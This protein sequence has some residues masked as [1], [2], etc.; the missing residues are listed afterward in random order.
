MGMLDVEPPARA[1]WAWVGYNQ[2]HHALWRLLF[3]CQAQILRN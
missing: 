1:D 2:E 3:S